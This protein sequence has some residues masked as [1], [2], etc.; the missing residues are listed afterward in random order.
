MV[1]IFSDLKYEESYFG[2]KQILETLIKVEHFWWIIPLLIIWDVIFCSEKRG[3]EESQLSGRIWS[4]LGGGVQKLQIPLLLFPFQFY[5]TYPEKTKR[6][7]TL[8]NDAWKT[9]AQST[10]KTQNIFIRTSATTARH[11]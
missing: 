6:A 11:T 3:L 9:Y 8:W 2:P 4:L 5:L 1:M 7:Q 10:L